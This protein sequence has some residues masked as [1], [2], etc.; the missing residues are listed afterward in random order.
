M[1]ESNTKIR[2]TRWRNT[3]YMIAENPFGVGPGNYEYGYI[4]YQNSFSQDLE[5]TESMVV[6]SP[7]NGFL[8]A[9]AE[10]GWACLLILIVFLLACLIKLLK[11]KKKSVQNA[12]TLKG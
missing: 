10:N 6:R 9:A 3:L 1:K 8:E 11:E 5:S 2:L 4:P 12:A 7:H